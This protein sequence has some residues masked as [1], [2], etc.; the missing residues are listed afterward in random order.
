MALPGLHLAQSDVTRGALDPSQAKKI[1][2]AVVEVVDDLIDQEDQSPTSKTTHDAEA[3]AAVE[4]SA[5]PAS[6]LPV[7]KKEQLAPGWEAEKPVLCVA[8]RS[9]R[10]IN[11]RHAGAQ[12]RKA[13]LSARVEARRPGR[14]QCL[15]TGNRGHRN[16]VPLIP[17][18]PKSGPCATIRRMR[19]KLPNARI[20]L[21]CWARMSMRRRS[22]GSQAG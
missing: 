7:L 19:R 3:A 21:G 12:L 13:R 20:L 11:R 8:G 14:S 22:L 6:L 1:K 2:D 9:C 16:G 4:T 18:R 10:Q 17:R 5:E 15:S